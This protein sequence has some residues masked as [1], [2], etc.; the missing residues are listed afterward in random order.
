MHGLEK[1]EDKKQLYFSWEH[2]QNINF[3]TP[4]LDESSYN[5]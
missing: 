3:C 5:L 1:D 4:V 2:I